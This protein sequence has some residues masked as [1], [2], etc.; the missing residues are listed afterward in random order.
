[1]S[2]SALELSAASAAVWAEATARP[3]AFEE[4]L[5]SDVAPDKPDEEG[6]TAAAVREGKYYSALNHL[7][8]PFPMFV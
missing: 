1:M 2:V 8:L 3:S 5:G 4:S 7:S 6:L